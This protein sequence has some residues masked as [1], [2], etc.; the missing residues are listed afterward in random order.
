MIEM[1][2]LS[3]RNV[4]K[5][6]GSV[7]AVANVS[8]EIE[9][10]EFLVLVGPSGC[11]KSTLLRIIAGLEAIEDGNILI[12]GRDMSTTDPKDRDVA[13]VFQNYAL[14]PHMTVFENMSFSL[15]QRRTSKAQIREIVAETARI[16]GLESLIDR[17]PSELSGGQRQRVAMGRAIVRNPSV[18]LLDEPLSNLDAKLR[19]RMR[20]ELKLLR[21]RLGV[22]TIY[23]THDQTEAMTLGDRVAVLKPVSN[24]NETNLQQIDTPQNLYLRPNSLF[25]A[26]FIGSPAMNFLYA[27]IRHAGREISARIVGTEHEI[28]FPASGPDGHKALEAYGSKRVVV[29]IRPEFLSINTSPVERG[30]QIFPADILISELVGPDAYLHFDLNTPEVGLGEIAALKEESESGK[31]SSRFVARVESGTL[32]EHLDGVRFSI[33]HRGLHFFDKDTGLAID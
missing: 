13:M 15:E 25:V 26:G 10:G 22:T 27:D 12:G 16:L 28:V 33:A 20:S 30:S 19:V 9:D 8:I 3:I 6:Y 1:A 23:V 14:Y 2:S 21:S 32:P 29:G 5:S 4:S 11:G 17:K 24:P 18:F 7:L 31:Q